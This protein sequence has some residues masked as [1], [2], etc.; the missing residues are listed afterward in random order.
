LSSCTA[1]P[2]IVADLVSYAHNVIY[3]ERIVI[4]TNLFANFL[5]TLT[6]GL[7]TFIDHLL[8]FISLKTSSRQTKLARQ[9]SSLGI[10]SYDKYMK[11]VVKID[12]KK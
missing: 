10:D 6:P 11:I 8:I 1:L 12:I 2:V 4:F 9:S 5:L 7:F 3:H